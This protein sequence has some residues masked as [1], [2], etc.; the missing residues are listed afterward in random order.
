MIEVETTLNEL[1][2]DAFY[3]L[4]AHHASQLNLIQEALKKISQMI[5]SDLQRVNFILDNVL[6]SEKC[7]NFTATLR[8]K[9]RQFGEMV[10]GVQ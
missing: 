4:P 10:D 5:R 8:L 2:S 3:D 9:V 6:D 1:D 7:Y